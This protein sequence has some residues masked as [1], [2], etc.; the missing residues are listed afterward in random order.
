MKFHDECVYPHLCIKGLKS[1]PHLNKR[2]LNQVF[3]VEGGV[4]LQEGRIIIHGCYHDGLLGNIVFQPD[5][6][7]FWVWFIS[8]TNKC[9]LNWPLQ[10]RALEGQRMW[11]K[12]RKFPS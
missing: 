2:A 3:R 11:N 12:P 5:K 4:D 8:N 6:G 1:K 10:Q 9:P 7:N